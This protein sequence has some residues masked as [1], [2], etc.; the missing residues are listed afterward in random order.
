[1]G[2]R[3]VSKAFVGWALRYGKVWWAIALVVSVPALVRTAWLY[4]HLRSDL[5]DLLPR[6]SPSVVALDELRRRV[7]A[8]QYL[9]VVVDA[10][11]TANLPAAERFIDDL[12]ALVRQYPAEQVSDVRTGNQVER[13][14]LDKHGAL[15]LDLSDLRSIEGRIEARRDYEAE[16]ETGGLLDEDTSAPPVDFSDIETRYERRLG[17]KPGRGE[18]GRYTSPE[19]HLT[20]LVIELGQYSTG[21]ATATRLIDRVKQGMASLGGTGRYAPGMRVGFGGDAAIAVEE[22]S[23]L[24]SDLT[25]SSLV[26][27]VGVMAAIVAYYRWWRSILI[28][29]PPLLVATVCAFAVASLPPFGVSSINSNTA[30]LGSIIIG[31]GINFGL[32]LLA[33]YVDERRAGAPVRASLERGVKGAR[34]G[35]LVAASAA[36]AAYGSL[37]ITHFRG[38]REFGYIGGLGMLFVWVAAF[39]LMPSL[40]GW[41]DRDEST[42][43][44]SP[45]ERARFSYWVARLVGRA[46]WAVFAVTTAIT[47]VAAYEVSRVR[48]G[49][50]IE[51]NFSR[52]RR[53]D[54][55]KSGQGY[56]GARMDAVVG[57]YLTPLALIGD[58]PDQARAVEARLKSERDAPAFAGRIDT[59]RSIEDVLPSNQEEKIALVLAIREDLTPRI[60]A[61]LTPGQRDYV[62]KLLGAEPVPIGLDDL[63]RTFTLG[64]REQDGRV[65]DVVL[66]YPAPDG[67]WWNGHAIRTFVDGLRDVARD[68]SL[69]GQP[70]RVAGS[71]ALSSD[72]AQAIMRDGARACVLAFA[73]VVAVVVVLLRFRRATV[74]VV[75]SL[76]IGLL[77]LAGPTHL[78]GIRINFANFIA[79]PITLGI[80]V[81]YAVNVVSRYEMDGRRDVLSAVR[82]T[83]AAVALCSLTTIIG[84]SSLLM[85]QNRGL[86]LFGL[87]AI[88]GEVACLGV[89]LA[90]LP[91]IVL[92]LQRRDWGK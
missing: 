79:F 25:V 74:Y 39:L 49:S 73:V 21:T 18:G 90:G 77:W 7:G 3:C 81:D 55:W 44:K 12:A 86:H 30:F 42:R 19:D 17:I 67:D 72:I 84:Y 43:P 85:A 10:G 48:W 92:L 8:H 20:V 59:I 57:E 41:L 46:P 33:R 68:S 31:N 34:G 13:A 69:G 35:T 62:D 52:L 91:A 26:V 80:G 83:G 4:R 32:I 6:D 45:P 76:L 40:V 38:F 9:G 64:L 47:V 51:S 28:V 27:L 37:S 36:A 22:L 1:M 24:V 2:K 54:T 89:A 78:L 16:R 23:A 50:D 53:R 5:E 58:R 88:L 29:G 87:L 56:W 82:S 71:V 63:P 14:F 15:Y 66:V 65:G 61:A 11:T 60:K 70:P 75:A